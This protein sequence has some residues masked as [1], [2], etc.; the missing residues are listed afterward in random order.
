[1][2]SGAEKFAR[3]WRGD[4]KREAA[5][6]SEAECEKG[7]ERVAFAVRFAPATFARSPIKTD[8]KTP[9]SPLLP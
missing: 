6:E 9:Y 3:R 7:Y 5:K 8:S 4:Q 2:K 1:M